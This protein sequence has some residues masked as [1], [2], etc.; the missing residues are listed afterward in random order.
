MI[1]DLKQRIGQ[2]KKD[3]P[4]NWAELVT[5]KTGKSKSWARQVSNGDFSKRDYIPQLTLI[6]VLE[7]IKEEYQTLINSAL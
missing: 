6:K 1:E 7:E 4:S 2:L 5:K 3:C